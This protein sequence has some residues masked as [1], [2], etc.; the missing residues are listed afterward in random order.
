MHRL[1]AV[2]A[3]LEIGSGYDEFI[4]IVPLRGKGITLIDLVPF[5]MSIEPGRYGLVILDAWYRFLPPGISEN[6]NAAV[7][8]LYNKIDAYTAHLGAAWVNVHHA[9]KGDQSGKSATD[10]GSGAGSQSRAADTHLIVRPHQ[11]ENVAVV[12]AVVRSWPPVERFCM[13]WE[14]PAWQLEPEADPRKLWVPPSARDRAKESRDAHMDEDRQAI[15]NAMLKMAE[16]QTKTFIRDS[17]IGNPRFGIAWASLITDKTVVSTGTVRKG[18]NR[19]Y[20]GFILNPEKG[21]Q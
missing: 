5:V 19:P 21:E 20:D 15:V 9:S 13:R 10:V 2:A 7:M 18:N 12:E 16:P 8:S 4:D 11:A 1:P 6:D 3:A 14:Y 17:S